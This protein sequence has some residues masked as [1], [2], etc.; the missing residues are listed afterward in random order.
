[1]LDLILVYVLIA[2]A[3]LAAGLA[4]WLWLRS[5][6]QAR[7]IEDLQSPLSPNN[8]RRLRSRLRAVSPQ[9]PSRASLTY[10]D[11]PAIEAAATIEAWLL[12]QKPQNALAAAKLAVRSDPRDW[13]VRLHFARV[14]FYCDEMEAAAQELVKA[15]LLG[16][17]S[18]AQDYLEAR[19]RLASAQLSVED[20]DEEPLEIERRIQMESAEALDMLLT[21]VERD[22]RFG[23]AAFHAGL[24]ALRIGLEPEGEILLRQ[25]G[26][27]MD[28]SPE[29]DAYQR[30]VSRLN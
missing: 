16:D 6:R 27:L 18:P 25:L 11:F 29:R 20:D 3:V 1:V 26:P 10:R 24:L 5:R 23:D 14:L 22:P 4:V 8:L 13:R 28:A 30:T 17:T 12:Q 21:V 7:K 15:R 19:I 2:V 9:I